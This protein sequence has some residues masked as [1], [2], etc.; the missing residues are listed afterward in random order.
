[1]TPNP[2]RGL[3]DAVSLNSRIF[4]GEYVLAPFGGLGVRIKHIIKYLKLLMMY[5]NGKL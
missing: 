5:L 1:M 3:Q 2:Q 4:C